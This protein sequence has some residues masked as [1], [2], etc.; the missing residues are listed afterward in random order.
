M[1][2]DVQGECMSARGAWR[3]VCAARGAFA[4]HE[5]NGHWKSCEGLAQASDPLLVRQMLY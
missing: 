3:T 2:E 5:G 4:L 1:R